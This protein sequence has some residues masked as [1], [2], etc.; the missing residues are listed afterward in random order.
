MLCSQHFTATEKNGLEDVA[1]HAVSWA[2]LV[3]PPQ[4]HLHLP[5]AATSEV[6]FHEVQEARIGVPSSRREQSNSRDEPLQWP[7]DG[8]PWRLATFARP[9]VL[10]ARETK[11]KK[12]RHFSLYFIVIFDFCIY[13][14]SNGKKKPK[15]KQT[16]TTKPSKTLLRVL[17][18][19][20]SQNSKTFFQE[21][22]KAH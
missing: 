15:P 4:L 7:I 12:T 20:R 14:S 21:G 22:Q 3:M 10:S 13:P 19:A 8:S 11:T 9:L 2:V 1:K 5:G 17:Q 18:G 16:T 6:K